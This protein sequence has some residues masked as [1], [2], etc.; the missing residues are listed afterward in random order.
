MEITADGIR[1][2]VERLKELAGNMLAE[3]RRASEEPSPL[4]LGEHGSYVQGI[5]NAA[6]GLERA[7]QVLADVLQ[8]ISRPAA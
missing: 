7:G 6:D 1:R 2:R 4:S 3:A 5:R 8:R